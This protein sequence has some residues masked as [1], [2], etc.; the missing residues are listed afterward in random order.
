[1]TPRAER[2][3]CSPKVLEV[4]NISIQF[5]GIAALDGLMLIALL[6]AVRGGFAGAMRIAASILKK[7]PV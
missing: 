5:N 4:C 2:Q 7:G 6:L 3:S 1:M